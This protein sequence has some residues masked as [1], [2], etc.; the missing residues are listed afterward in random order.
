[1][2]IRSTWKYPIH[3][4]DQLTVFSIS[5]YNSYSDNGICREKKPSWLHIL[6]T[7]YFERLSPQYQSIS[8]FD[9]Q[10]FLV[11]DSKWVLRQKLSRFSRLFPLFCESL[12]LVRNLI[13]NFW[14]SFLR[15]RNYSKVP[16]FFF[17]TSKHKVF[18]I[19]W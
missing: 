14:K 4:V 10:S 15:N 11:G 9:S 2:S 6:F 17:L 3:G 13:I 18:K 12:C 7:K 8:K 16:E 1:M 5:K 19:L